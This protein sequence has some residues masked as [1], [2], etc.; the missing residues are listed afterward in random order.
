MTPRVTV[1]MTVY[2]GLPYL[3]QAI[4]SV[5]QQTF[6]D[7]E[8]LIIDDGSTDGSVA[9]IRRYADPR[10]QLIANDANLGQAQSLNK[11]LALARAPYV[12]RM[13]QDDVCLPTRLHEQVAVLDRYPEVAV[14]GS[15]VYFVSPS[16]RK[17]GVIGMRIDDFGTFLGILLTNATPFGHPT[18]LFRREAV[19]AAGGYD[20]ALA[21]CEDYALWG[22]LALRRGQ[23]VVIPRPLVM[24]RIHGERQSRRQGLPQQQNARRA[25]DRLVAACCSPQDDATLVG[26]LLR[27]DDEFW[28]TCRSR[29]QVRIALRALEAMLERAREMFQLSPREDA[30]LRHRVY[31]WLG[32]G[33]F[34][35]M[36]HQRWQSLSMFLAVL[37][38]EP[39]LLRYPTV[40][41]YPVC[42]LASPLFVPALRQRCV[43]AAVWVGQ[44]KYVARLALRELRDRWDRPRLHERPR[45]GRVLYVSYDGLLEPL[46][47]SQV[48]SYLRPLARI[49][50][51][52]ILSYEKRH[53]LGNRSKMSELARDLEGHGIRWLRLRYHKWPPLVSTAYDVARGIVVGCV[54]CRRQRIRLVHARGYVP[55]VIGIVLKR[56]CGTTFLFDMRGFW[57]DEKVDA[58]HWTR[59]ALPY[60]LAKRWERRFFEQANAIVS[61]TAEGIAAFPALGYRIPPSTPAVVI[62]TCV[63]LA[64]FFPS[65]K[66]PGLL[67]RLQLRDRLV[68]GGAGNLGNWYLRSAMLE[69]FA[70]LNA[71]LERVAVLLVTRDDHER[72]R[73]DAAAAGLPPDRVVLIRSGFEEMPAYLRLMDLGVVFRKMQFSKQGSLAVKLGEFLATGVPMVINEGIGDSA[74]LIRQHRVGVVLSDASPANFATSLPDVKALL[75]DPMIHT[76]CREVAQR[77]F[78]LDAGV[79]SYLHLYRR[80]DGNSQEGEAG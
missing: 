62:P 51:V 52:T 38:E 24:M 26:A 1:L 79:M 48:V 28:R 12:A 8:F 42:W 64:R 44:Q 35:G 55:S 34:M 36:L 67:E 57:A 53:D 31:W 50:P 73:R 72:L 18:A 78:D 27:T 5:L 3:A 70:F 80:L 76:R 40:W 43:R 13:D 46:G 21:L 47:A 7:F 4:E 25:H 37:R 20:P 39:W 68:V 56:L 66:D 11:G 77:Y 19:L 69:Y 54:A 2:N 15:R 59:D 16:G 49:Y 17:R 45:P 75:G 29:H 14:V 9:C 10:I 41:S 65:P 71:H 22:A 6:R 23:A 60:R 32:H 74:P 61:L 33:A 63:D 58:G 30:A